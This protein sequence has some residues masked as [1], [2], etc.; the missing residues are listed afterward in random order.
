VS[1]VKRPATV[2]RRNERAESRRAVASTAQRSV[3]GARL[4]LGNNATLGGSEM[5]AVARS[6][7]L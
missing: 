7:A 2:F 1:V 3:E 6:Q 5:P 4:Q